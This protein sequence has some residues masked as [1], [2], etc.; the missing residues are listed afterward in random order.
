M[1]LHSRNEG[2]TL[3]LGRQI[4]SR[5]VPPR[6]LLL[7]GDLGSGKTVLARGIVEGL[8]GD[9][10][11]VTSPTFTLVN[12]Y[13]TPRGLVYHLDL[14]RL[15]TLKDLYSI[16]IEDILASDTIVIVE[17]ADKLPL[18]IDSPLHIRIRAEKEE[19]WLEVK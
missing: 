8:G 5:L 6:V 13:L 18:P 10:Q 19:R 3:Q 11:E 12:Q 9:P 15:D 1:K 7:E 16:G 17:W 2:E 14:Y 4:G